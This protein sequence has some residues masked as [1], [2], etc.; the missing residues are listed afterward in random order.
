MILPFV[1]YACSLSASI[2]PGCFSNV[3]R[4]LLNQE[5]PGVL[6]ASR[7]EPCGLR[8]IKTT[9]LNFHFILVVFR[10]FDNAVRDQNEMQLYISRVFCFHR[11]PSPLPPSVA[12]RIFTAN[13]IRPFSISSRIFST[14][15]SVFYMFKIFANNFTYVSACNILISTKAND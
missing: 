14:N 5:R 9:I 7:P 13:P 8:S 10:P 11:V 6:A 4:L 15:P 12:G 1:L 3:F 2:I